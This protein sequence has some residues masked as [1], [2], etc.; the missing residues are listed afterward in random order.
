[1]ISSDK[2]GVQFP[3]SER[4]LLLLLSNDIY[5]DRP[6]P[7]RQ[8]RPIRTQIGSLLVELREPEDSASNPVG[9]PLDGDLHLAD[10]TN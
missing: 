1:V 4:F 5:H 10:S 8:P 2:A 6:E 3:D 9:T 7:G